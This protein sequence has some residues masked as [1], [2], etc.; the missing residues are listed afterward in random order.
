[1]HTGIAMFTNLMPTFCRVTGSIRRPTGY[2]H[3]IALL[4]PLSWISSQSHRL[5]GLLK[6][7]AV[8]EHSLS[9]HT[10]MENPGTSGYNSPQTAKAVRM[11]PAVV[12]AEDTEVPVQHASVEAKCLI[13]MQPAAGY[14][15]LLQVPF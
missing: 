12:A 11:F 10:A 8:F 7:C 5:Q 4:H 1:M 15:S 6:T 9:L 3:A 2:P 14:C 13:G